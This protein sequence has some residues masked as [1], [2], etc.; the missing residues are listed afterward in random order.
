MNDKKYEHYIGFAPP[1]L[2]EKPFRLPVLFSEDG[3][4]VIEK[5][6]GVA[7]MAHTWWDT[8][9]L[10]QAIAIQAANQKRELESFHIQDL[11]SVFQLEP[12][13]GGL[14]LFTTNKDSAI[15]WN[16]AFGSNQLEFTFQFISRN[17]ESSQN[18]NEFLCDLPLIPAREN[19]L[20]VVSHRYGKKSET[21][22][23]RLKTWRNY[24]LWQATVKHFRLHQV[25][26]HANECAISVVG[27]KLYRGA[28]PIMLSSLKKKYR[29]GKYEERP[30]HPFP[31]IELIGIKDTRENA[32]LNIQIDPSKHF[33][34]VVKKLAEYNG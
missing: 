3:M 28:D 13:V 18:S 32:L 12:E 31:L 29:E 20:M 23:S 21:F 25:R 27:D 10:Q 22:F 1:L 6:Q 19:P 24:T 4:F 7:S 17:N 9:N 14:S 16:N 15:T 33:A 8:P 2:G 11:K 26:A 30:M 5:P 34:N